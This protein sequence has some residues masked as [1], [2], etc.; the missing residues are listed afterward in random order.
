L[1]FS[2]KYFNPER[3]SWRI[4]RFFDLQFGQGRW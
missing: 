3:M 2:Y 1:Q 4:G